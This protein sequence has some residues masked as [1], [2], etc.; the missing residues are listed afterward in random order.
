MEMYQIDL[1]E[2]VSL[3][4]YVTPNGIRKEGS[5]RVSNNRFDPTA[6]PAAKATPTDCSKP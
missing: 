2:A 4:R 3:Q 1:N 5:N 6:V